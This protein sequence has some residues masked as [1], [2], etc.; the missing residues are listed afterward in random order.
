[1]H[2]IGR[3]KDCTNMITNNKHI[4]QLHCKLW[5][6]EYGIPYLEDCS[7]N[8]T[9]VG[10]IKVGKGNK[11]SLNNLCEISLLETNGI[12]FLF[13]EQIEND[14]IHQNYDVRNQIGQGNFATVYLGI[15]KKTSEKVAIKMIDIKRFKSNSSKDVSTIKD[16]INILQEVN[17][18]LKNQNFPLQ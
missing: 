1:L 7:S 6:D 2:T 11:I 8:G 13:K 18:K 12:K 10:G 3:R 17:S 16:E 14:P 9:F 15:S 4:S 5:K